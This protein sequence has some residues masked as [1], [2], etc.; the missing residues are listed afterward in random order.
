[1]TCDAVAA[2]FEENVDFMKMYFEYINNFDEAVRIVEKW[3]TKED[4]NSAGSRFLKA[5]AQDERHSQLNLLGYL[6]LPVQRVPRYKLLLADLVAS[7]NA[8]STRLRAGYEKIECLARDI[9]DR[10]AEMEGRKRLVQLERT[11]VCPPGVME[12]YEGRLS[13][14]SKFVDPARRLVKEEFVHVIV[15]RKKVAGGLTWEKQ[16]EQKCLAISCSDKLFLVPFH[17]VMTLTIV[18]LKSR[19]PRTTTFIVSVGRNP[20]RKRRR[21]PL[22][23]IPHRMASHGLRPPVLL[24]TLPRRHPSTNRGRKLAVQMQQRRRHPRLA[25]RNLKSHQTQ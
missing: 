7:T 17:L 10:K 23:G 8:P 24:P 22:L 14:T 25:R 4:G 3:Q 20:T 5:R 13:S 1:M 2:V 11:V 15:R 9:N 16:L 6:L 19:N 12:E 18:Y 21:N